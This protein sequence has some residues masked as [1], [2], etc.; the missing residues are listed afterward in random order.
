MRKDLVLLGIALVGALLFSCKDIKSQAAD[1]N[2]KIVGLQSKIGRSMIAFSRTFSSNNMTLME[3]KYT[4]LLDSI[5]FAISRAEA[6][7][8]FNGNSDF[9]DTAIKLFEF[10]RISAKT[11]TMKFSTFSVRMNSQRLMRKGLKNLPRA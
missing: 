7:E 10:Y 2:D 8:P 1:Y 9:R 11:S 3:N 6:M 5:D 4:E